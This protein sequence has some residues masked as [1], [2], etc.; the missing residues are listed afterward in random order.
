MEKQE[1]LVVQWIWNKK[2]QRWTIQAKVVNY[3]GWDQLS[4]YLKHTQNTSKITFFNASHST[5]FMK[6][7]SPTILANSHNQVYNCLTIKYFVKEF[8]CLTIRW[9]SNHLIG[10]LIHLMDTIGNLMLSLSSRFFFEFLPCLEWPYL[11]L[12]TSMKSWAPNKE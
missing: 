11:N 7:I 8:S 5:K 3:N 12:H 10:L 1:R 9:F 4:Y 6:I 2:R